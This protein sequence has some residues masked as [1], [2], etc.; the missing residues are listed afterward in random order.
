[1]GAKDSG[2]EVDIVDVVEPGETGSGWATRSPSD[3]AGS[4]GDALYRMGV[5]RFV[6]VEE[7]VENVASEIVDR[8]R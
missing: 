6:G 7:D 4:G 1:M 2:E 8:A 5:D 3:P